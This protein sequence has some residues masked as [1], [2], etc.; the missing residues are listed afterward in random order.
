MTGGRQAGEPGAFEREWRR[1]FE[2]FAQGAT[3]EHQISGW[4]EAGLRRRIRAFDEL[5][6]SVTVEPG[7][8]VLDLGSGAGTYVRLLGSQG[9]R[10]VGV[11]YSIPSLKRSIEADRE[12]VGRYLCGDAYSLPFPDRA[13]QL[14]VMIG[15]FQALG[16]PPRALAEA[17]RVLRPGGH[18]VLEILNAQEIIIGARALMDRAHRRPPG[19]RAYRRAAMHG[20]LRQAGL[21]PLRSVPIFLPPRGVPAIERWLDHPPIRFVLRTVPICAILGAPAFLVLAR[22][23]DAR[24]A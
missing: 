10:P 6:A 23:D 3:A 15:I 22:R 13:F 4:S 7:S 24:P 8:P 20:W 16:E 21:T 14:V 11:D 5:M 1:R 17:R 2:R 9:Y 18:I 12:G 19:V